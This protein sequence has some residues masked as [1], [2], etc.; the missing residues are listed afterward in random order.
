M[1]CQKSSFGTS[2]YRLW[3]ILKGNTNKHLQSPVKC[4]ALHYNK[5]S[6]SQQILF[7]CK[8]KISKHK[9]GNFSPPPPQLIPK[10]VFEPQ[11]DKT[12]KVCVLLAK[13]PISLGIHPVWSKSSLSSWRKLGYLA[14]HWAHSED[15]DQTGQMP[16]LIGVFAGHTLILLVLSCHG[17]FLD[18][19]LISF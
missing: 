11:H 14:T 8:N 19:V 16:R 2:Y 5:G 1:W 10:P 17:S 9:T 3:I 12:N 4:T 18:T 6:G 13:T 15:S 7:I